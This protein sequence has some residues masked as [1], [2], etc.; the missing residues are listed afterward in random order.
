VVDSLKTEQTAAFFP[1]RVNNQGGKEQPN[2]EPDCNL[3][4]PVPDVEDDTLEWVVTAGGHVHS[5]IDEALSAI[6][7][8]REEGLPRGYLPSRSNSRN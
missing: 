1:K 8:R 5:G 6:A 7:G 4:H 2:R 3:H